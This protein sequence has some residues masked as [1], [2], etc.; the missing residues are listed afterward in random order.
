MKTV[1]L[2]PL[3]LCS[4]LFGAIELN[5]ANHSDSPVEYDVCIQ[6]V[7]YQGNPTSSN[8]IYGYA[9]TNLE[10]GEFV[11]PSRYYDNCF[12]G[13]LEGSYRFDSYQG[14]FC[15]TSSQTVTLSSALE[16][17]DGVIVI[18]LVLWCE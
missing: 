11:Y 5:Q 3:F 9:A 18:N 8:D 10:T 6:L 13:M 2:L 15:G 12:Y 16:N 14:Y 1:F 17:E 7:D 4:V